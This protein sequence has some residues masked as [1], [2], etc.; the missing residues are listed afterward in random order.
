MIAI[1]IYSLYHHVK[2]L[3]EHE[4][5]GIEQAGG[6]C[7]IYKVQE[8]LPAPVLEK[9]HAAPAMDYPLATPEI[10]AECD[11]VI[12]G[13][14]TRFG[15]V[16]A[17]MKAFLD[18]TGG[19][20]MKGGLVGKPCACFFSTAGIHG[21]QETTAMSLM[22]FFAH[23]GML[24][25]PLG[26]AHPKLQNNKEVRGGSAWGAGCVADNDGSRR[27]SKDE[28]EIAQHQGQMFYKTAMKLK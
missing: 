15:I 6:K 10:L 4:K 16:P 3:A 21:G 23:H 26:F 5:K 20:W 17:Q 2:E 19:L 24:F 14:P 25:V 13:F 22:P 28:L 18:S 12:F 9:M 8:T 11:G 27:P 1:I 7:T